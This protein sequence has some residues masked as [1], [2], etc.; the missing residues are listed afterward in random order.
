MDSLVEPI[1]DYYLQSGP[2]SCARCYLR[3]WQ[4]KINEGIGFAR[5]QATIFGTLKAQVQ[6]N[7]GK[8]IIRNHQDTMDAR[9]ALTELVEYYRNS[10]RVIAVG[11]ALHQE[12]LTMKLTKESHESWHEF[13]SSYTDTMCN[14]PEHTH[15]H[16][17][18][19]MSQ[20]QLLS[21]LQEA[22][23]L[24]SELN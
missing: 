10:T 8:A 7:T 4:N 15:G 9:A 1:Q 5:M 20:H 2:Q 14:C 12:L 24:D 13:L 21:Y 16:E 22:I 19:Q 6:T 11:H 18:A 23:S 3:A 17:E